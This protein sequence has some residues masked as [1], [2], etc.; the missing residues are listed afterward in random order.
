MVGSVPKPLFP[1]SNPLFDHIGPNE[2][3]ELKDL[4][5]RDIGCSFDYASCT[6]IYLDMLEEDSAVQ[7]MNPVPKEDLILSVKRSLVDRLLGRRMHVEGRRVL[8]GRLPDGPLP[9]GRK[10]KARAVGRHRVLQDERSSMVGRS[11]PCRGC[12]PTED[13]SRECSERDSDYDLIRIT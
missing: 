2:A 11:W 6:R 7:K 8:I 12:G 10:A 4:V 1:S 5:E 9:S 3:R 13:D